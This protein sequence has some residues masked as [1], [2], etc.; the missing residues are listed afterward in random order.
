M[1]EPHRMRLRNGI[2]TSNLVT[3]ETEPTYGEYVLASD[4]D[5][6]AAIQVE[7]LIDLRLKLGF[8]DERIHELETAATGLLACYTEDLSD[9]NWAPI[10][11]ALRALRACFPTQG[12][13]HG[14]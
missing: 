12:N 2:R 4:Y 5:A 6:L 9:E 8:R 3:G 10:F 14:L 1:S 7:V 11:G 13:D